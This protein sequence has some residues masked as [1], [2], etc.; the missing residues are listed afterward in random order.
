M[1]GVMEAAE[2]HGL[3]VEELP[4]RLPGAEAAAEHLDPHF[5]AENDVVGGEE[6]PEC[7][8]S[9]VGL[10]PPFVSEDLR[11]AEIHLFLRLGGRHP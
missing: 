4:P 3:P 2:E 5:H 8:A 6:R 1:W 11:Q 7:S 10:D 9:A